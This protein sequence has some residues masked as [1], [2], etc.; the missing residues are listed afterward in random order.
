MTLRVSQLDGI[1]TLTVPRGTSDH[2]ASKFLTDNATWLD[3]A[4]SRLPENVVVGAGTRLPIEGNM[5]PVKIGSVRIAKINGN[6]ITAPE[7]NT[8]ATLRIALKSAART[9]L[10]KRVAVYSESI[11]RNVARITIRDPRSRWGSCSAA[12][13]LMFSWRLIMAPREILDYVAAHEVAHLQ[14]MNHS[15]AFWAVVHSLFPEH[16]S[17]R[18]WLR[19]EGNQLHRYRFD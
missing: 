7:S 1:A 14:E 19:S 18:R 12:G 2:L 3:R 17:A 8:A 4:R 13:N 16:K 6:Q 11:G 9:Q 10:E 15:K 5:L